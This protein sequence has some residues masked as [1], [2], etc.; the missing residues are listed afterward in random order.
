MKML[1]DVVSGELILEHNGR[2]ERLPYDA[3]AQEIS[4]TLH[5]LELGQIVLLDILVAML[6]CPD[7]TGWNTETQ[8]CTCP[9]GTDL[10]SDGTCRV[11]TDNRTDRD[12]WI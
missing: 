6:A 5:L 3:T 8:T 11:H 12:Y 9:Y 10:Q 2:E 4:D 1:L 7:G